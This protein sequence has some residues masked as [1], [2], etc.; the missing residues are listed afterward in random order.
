M[1]DDAVVHLWHLDPDRLLGQSRPPSVTCT[2][3]KIV[4]VGESGVGSPLVAA[5]P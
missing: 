2:S 4:L 3:A 1:D 5:S